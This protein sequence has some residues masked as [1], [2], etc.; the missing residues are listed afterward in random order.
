MDSG[1]CVCDEGYSGR[2]WESQY[3]FEQLIFVINKQIEMYKS[4]FIM[5]FCFLCKQQGVKSE[6]SKNVK[7][8]KTADFE[9]CIWN[10]GNE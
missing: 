7:R 8:G 5:G 1:L 2:S 6:K 10:K 3:H 4:I 9:I